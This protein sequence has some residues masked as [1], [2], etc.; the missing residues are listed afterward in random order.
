MQVSHYASV[1]TM[2][3]GGDHFQSKAVD[4]GA[5]LSGAVNPVTVELTIGDD[6]GSTVVTAEFD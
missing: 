4:Q 1:R 3:L 2:H 5:H 6:G